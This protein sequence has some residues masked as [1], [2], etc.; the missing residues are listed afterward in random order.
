MSFGWPSD[1][2]TPVD[3]KDA[4]TPFALFMQSH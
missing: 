4:V 1:E 3:M 2:G